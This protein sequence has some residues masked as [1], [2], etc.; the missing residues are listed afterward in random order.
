MIN[1]YSSSVKISEEPIIIN[2]K[3][4][5]SINSI[6]KDKCYIIFSTDLHTVWIIKFSALQIKWSSPL[7]ELENSLFWKHE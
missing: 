7:F 2:Y 6:R 3:I 4:N 5:Q 1:R